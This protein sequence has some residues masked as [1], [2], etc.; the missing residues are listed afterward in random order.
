MKKAKKVNLKAIPAHE[1]MRKSE[2]L[3]EKRDRELTRRFP[4]PTT[5]DMGQDT[6]GKYYRPRLPHTLTPEEFQARKK[7]Y[8]KRVREA[9]LAR[10]VQQ[11]DLGPILGITKLSLCRIEKGKN[12]PSQSTADTIEELLGVK[13]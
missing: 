13:W 10:E 2:T 9:R 7:D 12:A 4:M 11:K 6:P 1:W 3:I 5:E 8:G